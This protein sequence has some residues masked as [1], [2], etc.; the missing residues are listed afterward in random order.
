MNSIKTKQVI[1]VGAGLTGLT[2]AYYLKK[3][4]F[5]VLVLEK[6]GEIGGAMKT[7]YKDGFVFESGANTGTLG[8]PDIAELFDELAP[9][10]KLEIANPK[11]KKRLILKNGK[12]HA[13]PNG[14][15]SAITTPLF[16]LWDKFRILGEPFRKKSKNPYETV[17]QVTRRRMG[18]SFLDYAIDP[19]VSGI[20]AGNPEKLVFR[21]ALPKMWALEDRYGSFIKGGVKRRREMKRD[22]RLSRATREVISAYGGFGNLINALA[23]HIGRK[24]ILCKVTDIQIKPVNKKWEVSFNKTENHIT[25]ANYLITTV[26]YDLPNL[27][28]FL[29]SHQLQTLN[30][31]QYAKIV[32]ISLGFKKWNGP[33]IQAF[34]GLIPSKENRKILGVL[35][36]SSF[37]K[38]RTPDGGALLIAYMGGI[39]HP[40]AIELTDNE[41]EKNVLSELR[42]ILK[43]P[44]MQP[45][46]IKIYRH[47]YAIPQYERNTEQRIAIIDEVQKQYPGLII[48][49][50]L[51]NGI[52]MADR[53]KQARDIA[54]KLKIG[55]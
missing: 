18:N 12:F 3:A 38:D 31:A 47:K 14:L 16:S 51:H 52:S 48:G 8:T 44:E 33:S 7:S 30:N 23:N 29:N 27:L 25:E 13:L 43:Y 22:T 45:D 2:T 55:G 10:V 24:N 39:R 54:N 36:P 9:Q 11:A 17:A 5:N 6:E 34:G 28:S 53:I 4:G 15:F 19:F 42:D 21:Y 40:E 32:S 26:G 35:F 50:N 1:I 46:I 41:I 20:Y 49:G 37:F